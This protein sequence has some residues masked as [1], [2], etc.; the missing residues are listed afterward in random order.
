MDGHVAHTG[1][2]RNIR[3]WSENPKERDRCSSHFSMIKGLPYGPIHVCLSVTNFSYEV[4]NPHDHRVI[5]SFIIIPVVIFIPIIFTLLFLLLL[6]SCCSYN[7]CCYCCWFL[8]IALIPL[9]L[10]LLG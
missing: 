5:V 6:Y 2:I 7:S 3:C 4:G 10:S 8:S 1:D 9:A